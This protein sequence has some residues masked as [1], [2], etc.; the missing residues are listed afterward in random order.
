[1]NRE[2]FFFTEM[3]YTAYSQQEA[4]RLGYN[5]LM[6]PNDQFDPVRKPRNFTG[7]TSRSCSIAPR[8][9]SMA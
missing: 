9:A 1:M 3:G 4:Q 8:R 6:F 5:N 7:C 2:V